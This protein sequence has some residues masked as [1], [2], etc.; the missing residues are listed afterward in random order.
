[1]NFNEWLQSRLT[2]HGYAV[3]P[4][5]GIVGELTVGALKAFEKAHGL[6]VDGRAD[7]RVVD[8]LRLPSSRVSPAVSAAIGD[9]DAGSA[10]L[11]PVKNIWPTQAGVPAF[12]GAV[13]TRQT[14]VKVPWDI[15]LAWEPSA[16]IQSGTI[17]VHEKVAASVE[18]VL[19]RVDEIY[20]TA[21]KRDLGL[22]LFGGSLNVRR[23]RGGSRYSMH[24]WGIAID[25]DPTRNALNTHR[26]HARLSHDD[27]A[28]WWDAW[29]DEGW[30]SLGR[31]RNYDW[32]HIQAAR[33]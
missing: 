24:S 28:P 7:Q 16:R 6:P 3:G 19:H 25:W 23:M 13:G 21:E 18:R 26:P 11:Y 9:R 15:Y 1:M 4:I 22:H 32:M 20:S 2:A 10:K 14:K 17:T 33:L 5:D 8:A 27:A 30:V 29:E 31:A 12:Y